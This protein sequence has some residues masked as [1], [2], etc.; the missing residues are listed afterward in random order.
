MKAAI[1]ESY[2]PPEVVQVRELPTPNPKDHEV[3]I[4]VH[5]TTV[6]SGDWRVRSLKLPSP[7]FWLPARIMFGLTRPKKSILGTELSGEIVQVGKEVKKFK[8]GDQVLAVTGAAFGAHAE[9]VCLSENAVIVP[10]P[11]GLSHEEAAS[12]P[13]GGLTSLYYLRDLAKVQAG[14]KVMIYGASGGLGT[15]AVQLAKVL[16]ANVVGVCS[17]LNRELVQSL[18]ADEVIDYTRQDLDVYGRDYDVIF[19]TVGKISF[20]GC[21]RLLKE[22]GKFL[23]AVL[24]MTEFIQILGTSFSNGKKVL[25]GVSIEKIDD[26][27]YLTGLIEAGK[28][29]AVIDRVYPFEQIR[30]A[31][32][33]VDSGRKKGSVV[34]FVPKR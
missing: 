26:L 27:L 11:S 2:G 9:F 33:L 19:D 28:L 34:V 8:K 6:T 29:K 31:H 13:F 7:V 3:L 16:G 5:A 25:G 17:T 12:I 30:E 21:K 22:R 24:T 23:A 1:Y 20:A 15:S 18:G 4:Q 32:R 14:Q 10:K